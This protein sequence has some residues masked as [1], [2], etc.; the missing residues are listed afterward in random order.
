MHT[1]FLHSPWGMMSSS[2][3]C[4]LNTFA[5]VLLTAWNRLVPLAIAAFRYIMVCRA[6]FVHN[7]GGEK[8]VVYTKSLGKEVPEFGISFALKGQFHESFGL[9]VWKVLMATLSL[10]SVSLCVLIILNAELSHFY[11]AC[12]GREELFR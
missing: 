3:L 8:Q 5:V 9:K 12:I 4:L 10:V 6:V 1:S 7:L 2:S 11:L